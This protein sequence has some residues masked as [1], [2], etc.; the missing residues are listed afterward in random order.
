[1]KGGCHSGQTTAHYGHINLREV[2]IHQ[3]DVP[4]VFRIVHTGGI[5]KDRAT[6]E[7]RVIIPTFRLGRGG[8]DAAKL[9]V[10]G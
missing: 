8:P 10:A 5:T 1:M 3:K 4:T 2:F 9:P 6:V 7:G